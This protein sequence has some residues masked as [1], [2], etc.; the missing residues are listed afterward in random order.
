MVAPGTISEMPDGP[1]NK[2][3][4]VDTHQSGEPSIDKTDINESDQIGLTAFDVFFIGSG[5]TFREDDRIWDRIS[6]S[7]F[8]T[9]LQ[10]GNIAFLFGS[11]PFI[12]PAGCN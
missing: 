8:D 10:N 7:H 12:L 2:Y 9:D 11:G 5:V 1:I 4:L 6:Y 3:G